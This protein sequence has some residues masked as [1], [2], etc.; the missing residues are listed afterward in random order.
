LVSD[1]RHNIHRTNAWRGI[2]SRREIYVR[3][4]SRFYFR[5]CPGDFIA[6][7]KL[8]GARR[9]RSGSF[10]NV[11]SPAQAN[12]S[13]VVI[14]KE[15]TNFAGYVHTKYAF[16]DQKCGAILVDHYGAP[17][18]PNDREL[19]EIEQRACT[20]IAMNTRDGD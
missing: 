10:E 14:S 18:D 19:R 9:F 12:G 5:D 2:F 20:E 1:L 8:V 4:R 6:A 7:V 15:E 16:V 13:I 3:K 17:I 11:D